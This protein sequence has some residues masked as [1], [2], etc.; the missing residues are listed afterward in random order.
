M[1]GAGST[2]AVSST[3]LGDVLTVDGM[4]V[5]LLATDEQGAPTCTGSCAATWPAVTSEVTA[6]A[7]VDASLI[8]TVAGAEGGSQVTYN[9]WP[10]Y[11]YGLDNA[12]GDV[13]GQGVSDVWFVISPAGE[14]VS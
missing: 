12:P 13:N 2:L 3:S 7:G 5:Y 4:T 10:I 6:G 11:F 9:G 14:P 8:G 1:A